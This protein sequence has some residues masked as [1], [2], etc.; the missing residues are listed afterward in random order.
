MKGE[1]VIQEIVWAEGKE[2]N[3]VSGKKKQKKT[4]YQMCE[5]RDEA[6]KED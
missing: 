3:R 6:V 4:Q 1:K 5:M 2:K